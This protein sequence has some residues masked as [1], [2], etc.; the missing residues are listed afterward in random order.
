MQTDSAK[1]KLRIFLSRK[2]GSPTLIIFSLLLT[3]VPHIYGQI[4][5][6]RRADPGKR[7]SIPREQPERSNLPKKQTSLNDQ[8]KKLMAGSPEDQARYADFLKQSDTG[9]FRLFPK[10]DY[11]TS[12]TVDAQAPERSLPV[13][14][15]GAYYSFGNKSHIFGSWSDIC[16]QDNAL[17][18][19]V[20]MKS[21]GLFTIIG[22][23]PLDSVTLQ[24]PGI[25]FL[26]KMTIPI[27][28]PELIAQA[29]HYDQ[30]FQEGEF[31][32]RSGVRVFPSQTYILRSVIYKRS[33]SLAPNPETGDSLM[34]I[35][36]YQGADLLIAFSVVRQEED[37]TVTILWKC[38]KRSPGPQLETN[39]K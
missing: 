34:H 29:K 32:Y 9:L 17:F 22:D 31:T 26:T 1:R 11:K 28:W 14:G 13:L 25:E 30:G 23:V 33:D 12:L 24:T 27:Q 21:M 19:Q 7:P 39:K 2:Y 37:G 35:D 36:K 20:A 16:L 18:T 38:L 10:I 3:I 8:Q 15:G 4:N 5:D 6:P